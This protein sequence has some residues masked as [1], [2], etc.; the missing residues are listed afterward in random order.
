MENL[1]RAVVTEKS[2][3]DQTEGSPD[4]VP[5][6]LHVSGTTLHKTFLSN[7]WNGEYKDEEEEKWQT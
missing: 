6:G 4:C 7:E 3:R 2:R 1:T 5:L